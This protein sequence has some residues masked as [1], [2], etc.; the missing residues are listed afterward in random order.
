[1]YFSNNQQQLVVYVNVAAPLTNPRH[2][3]RNNTLS[4]A[5]STILTLVQMSYPQQDLFQT[6]P[7]LTMITMSSVLAYCFA[8]TLLELLLLFT[9]RDTATSSTSTYDLAICWCRTAMMGFG[10]VSVAS[11]LWLLL[12]HHP[13]SWGPVMYLILCLAF[14]VVLHL[15]RKAALP[16][17]NLLF[18][19]GRGPRTSRLLPLNTMDSL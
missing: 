13:R 14:P 15:A 4:F 6:N 5:I 8:F 7:T 3:H 2:A 16:M 9:S 19:R 1:M 10:S 11:L 12:F 17:D 18:G